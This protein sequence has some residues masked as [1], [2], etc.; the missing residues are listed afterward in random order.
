M[1]TQ[2]FVNTIYINIKETW[3]IIIQIVKIRSKGPITPDKIHT[4]GLEFDQPQDIAN[5]FNIY[6]RDIGSQLAEKIS[7]SNKNFR[8]Y[9]TPLNSHESFFLT[10]TTPNEVD[11]M[12]NELNAS[13]ALGPHGIPISLLKLAKPVIASELS[14]IYNFSF[15]SGI[16]PEELKLSR[17]IP[18]YKSES[19]HLLSNYRPISLLSPFSK[20]LE[21][22]MDK[23]L[24]SYLNKKDIL[25]KYQFGFW[26]NHSTTLALIEIIDSILNAM[27]K[28]LYTCG[29]FIDFS[30]AFDTINHTILLSKLDHYGIR[31][32][33]LH[34]FI[35]DRSQFV[36]FNG[37]LSNTIKTNCGVPQGSNLGPLLFLI[38]INDISNCSNVL[39]LRLFA[40]DTN[41]FLED[42]NIL[43][44]T[45]IVNVELEKLTNWIKANKLSLNIKKSKFM[46]FS[47]IKKQLHYIPNINLDGS[48]LE[49]SEFFKYLG[50]LLDRNLSWKFHINL[51]C[52]TLFKNIGIISKLCY[53]VD[54]DTLKN[55][56]YSLI[57][58]YLYNGAVI[59]GNTYQSRINQLNILNNKV[60]RI[61]TFSKPR[62]HAPPL[63][64]LLGILQVK[65][66]VYTQ[67]CNFMYDYV[68]N[69]LPEAFSN[70]FTHSSEIHQHYTRY[71]THNFHLPSVSS[72]SG[73]FSLKFSGI[74]TWNSLD[75]RDKLLPRKSLIKRI[76]KNCLDTYS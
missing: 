70:Y 41:A 69:R 49:Q 13:K 61:M 57:Y 67:K 48:L 33:A 1:L 8:E 9:L 68:N 18:L 59:W 37:A 26:K 5:Q 23:C 4:N 30:K 24:L 46:I 71:S 22:L 40:D 20:I 65:D 58:P 28:G 25:Y 35:T 53:Y 12:I 32:V 36:D 34:W 55:V 63:Y 27:D 66:I 52:K 15:T 14:E 3:K 11:S 50:V 56:Y 42:S 7:P 43:T 64:K 60:I 51:I 19:I 74:K 54:L 76:K 39:K 31:G 21:K 2:L 45:T 44:L 38:Y 17:V 72:N 47:S 10:P 62:S 73:K 29:I 6:F 75:N 16:F